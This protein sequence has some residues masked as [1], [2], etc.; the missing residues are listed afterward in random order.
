MP[1]L[2]E[3]ETVRFGLAHLLENHPK[4]TRVKLT[5]ADIRFP[6]P[7]NFAKLLEGQ[8][9][10]GVR[11]RAKYLLI[12]TDKISLLSHLGMTGSWRVETPASLMKSIGPHDHCF[13]EL[14]DK[15]TLIYRDPRRFGV[16]DLVKPGEEE[17]HL[18]LRALGPEPLDETKFTTEFL[19]EL[20]RKRKTALKVFIMDQRVVVGVGNIYASEVLFRAK[21]RPQK[22]A[23]KMTKQEAERLVVAIRS[24]LK[25]AIMAGGSSIRD[26]K[27][28]EGDSGSF[29]SS[30]QVYE[31]A[32]E[33]CRSCGQALKSKVLGG[34]STY[35][36][37]TCQKV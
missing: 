32:G 17:T 30:H 6:I 4:I 11:R 25:A 12:E 2:P 23:G 3:V 10:T 33:P 24:I 22:R 27:N 7:K 28:A 5:R 21:I 15:R 29:Q 26:Y 9:I 31:R 20:S 37:P 8:T 14:S 18:R 16:L 1:E 13:I 35:W 34:R 36:C 19:F